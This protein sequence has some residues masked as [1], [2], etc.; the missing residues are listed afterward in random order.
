MVKF[1]TTAAK[2]YVCMW[3]IQRQL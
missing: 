2:Q 1:I 3:Y